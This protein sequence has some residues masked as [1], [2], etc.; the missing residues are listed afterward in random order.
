MILYFMF[1][2][3]GINKVYDKNIKA[4]K[5]KTKVCYKVLILYMKW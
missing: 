5:G 3:V 4:K 1:Y 2:K